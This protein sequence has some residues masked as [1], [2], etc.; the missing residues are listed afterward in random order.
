VRQRIVSTAREDDRHPRAQHDA[1]G[2][3]IGQVFQ[4][5]G[6][7]VTRFEIRHDQNV[8]L[9]SDWGEEAFRAGRFPR[10]RGIKRQRAIYHPA[11]DLPRS[12]ILH[13]APASR[14]EGIF[15][16]TVSTAERIAT[17]GVSIPRTCARS[18]AFWTISRFA[19]RSG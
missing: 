3:R 8:G 2:L 11:S 1:R 15:G 18:M 13:S 12:A 4:L 9:T 14:V 19:S 6:Q 10:H 7:H 5:L 17:L 16:L